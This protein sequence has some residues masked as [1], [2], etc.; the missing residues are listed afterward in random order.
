VNKIFPSKNPNRQIPDTQ[1]EIEK[2]KKLRNT[3]T[4]IE[5]RSVDYYDHVKAFIMVDSR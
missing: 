1:K 3:P 5:Y 4:P 2:E